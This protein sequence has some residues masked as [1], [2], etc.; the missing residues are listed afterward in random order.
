M[1]SSFS[2]RSSLSGFGVVG[3]KWAAAVHFWLR[4]NFASAFSPAFWSIAR[5]W[6]CKSG[7]NCP[8]C[9]SFS[10]ST[11]KARQ[12]ARLVAILACLL[13]GLTSA[14]LARAAASDD[15]GWLGAKTS[16]VE[17][18]VVFP[19]APGELLHVHITAGGALQFFVD[20]ASISV[21]P[22]QTVRYTLVAKAPDGPR[23]VTYEGIN[24]ARRQWK[25]YA[26]WNDSTKTW[27][28]ASTSDWQPIPERGAERI[29][30]TLISD[31][32]CKDWATDGTA[33]EMAQRIAQ[34]LR[35]IQN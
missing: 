1:T 8:R 35:Y 5:L 31:D 25:L 27:V 14:Q 16:K 10:L 24:C 28:A 22:G 4:R 7:K 9:G 30:S 29:H 19:G 11:T 20:R 34:G 12:A 18:P 21:Q 15:T 23:N 2:V 26:L 33:A 32:F 6:A 13:A 3:C 17:S